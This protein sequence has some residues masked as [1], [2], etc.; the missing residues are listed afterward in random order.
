MVILACSADAVDVCSAYA[1]R[2]PILAFSKKVQEMPGFLGQVGFLLSFFFF[3][4][5]AYALA[6]KNF[7]TSLVKICAKFSTDLRTFFVCP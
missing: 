6:C 2:G 5:R 1:R 4:N 3:F 7:Y